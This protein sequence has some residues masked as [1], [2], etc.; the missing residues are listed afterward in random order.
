MS[1]GINFDNLE[2]EPEQPQKPATRRHVIMPPDPGNIPIFVASLKRQYPFYGVLLPNPKIPQVTDYLRTNWELLHKMSGSTC[3]LVTTFPPAQLTD[4]LRKFLVSLLSEAD[5]DEVWQRYHADPQQVAGDEYEAASSFGVDLTRLPCLVLM[6]DL[7]S[8]Q[9]LIQ[10]L[11]T[12]EANDLTLL[13]EEVFSRINQ[14]RQ[15][16]DPAKRL[17]S[18]KGE[19]GMALMARLQAK[20]AAR[21]IHK[22][23][24]Q[25]DWPEVIKSTLTNQEL[26]TSAFKAVLGAFGLVG[27]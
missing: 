2:Q 5:A 20:R 4:S 19:L 18:L 13:F 14:H 3:L 25:V 17:E 23:L 10:R 7:D 21:G 27:G 11:P 8:N 9:K 26:M 15:E 24:S 12:W 16:S 1:R 22:T 6:T